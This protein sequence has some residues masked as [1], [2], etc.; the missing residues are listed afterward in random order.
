MADHHHPERNE[1]NGTTSPKE[2]G[3]QYLNG[4][5]NNE[6]AVPENNFECDPN[7]LRVSP[8]YNQYFETY[9]SNH[10]YIQPNDI[11]DRS[12]NDRESV[13]EESPNLRYGKVSNLS[14]I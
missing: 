1:K 6:I 4:I 5:H 2:E 9:G 8:H 3:H 12:I 11:I 10:N 7:F 13:I 14:N